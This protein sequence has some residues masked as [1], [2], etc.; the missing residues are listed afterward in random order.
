[1]TDLTS[2]LFAVLLLV[3]LVSLV[4]LFQ[5]RLIYFPV[6]YSTAQLEEARTVGAQEVKFRTRQGNQAAFFF[7]HEHRETTPENLWL[8]FG[9]NGDVALEWLRLVRSFPGHRTGFL[10]IDGGSGSR[11][12]RYCPDGSS[13]DSVR[14]RRA[15]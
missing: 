2:W 10:L 12:Q 7:R 14:N 11:P 5:H 15:T 8:L 6:R 13:P 4:L 3:G 9:G 1:M